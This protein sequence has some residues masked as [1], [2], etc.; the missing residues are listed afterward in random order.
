MKTVLLVVPA[1][2]LSGCRG[3]EPTGPARGNDLGSVAAIDL[4]GSERDLTPPQ[5]LDCCRCPSAAGTCTN[6]VCLVKK[7]TPTM[8][9]PAPDSCANI[10]LGFGYAC[11]T[12]CSWQR[13]NPETGM[14]ET[15]IEAGVVGYAN[16]RGLDTKTAYLDTC[17]QVPPARSTLGDAYEGSTCCCTPH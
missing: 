2:L 15:S 6:N 13:F 11:S 12:Q 3:S 16:A 9:V 14:V 10:C 5:C 7:D 8:P 17:D 1:L 4:S